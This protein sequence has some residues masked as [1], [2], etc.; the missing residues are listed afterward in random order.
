MANFGL[1]CHCKLFN[2]PRLLQYSLKPTL[3]KVHGKVQLEESIT[4]VGG[5]RRSR[6]HIAIWII[7]HSAAANI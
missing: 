1:F 7:L 2:L 6:G 3:G 5:R 4:A